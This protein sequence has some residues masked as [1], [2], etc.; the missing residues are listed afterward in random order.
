VTP[1]S[2][3]SIPITGLLTDAKLQVT[4]GYSPRFDQIS[5]LLIYVAGRTDVGRIPKQDLADAMGLSESQVKNLTSLA[6]AMDLVR[7]IVY[8]PTEMGSLLV[9]HDPF[10]DDLGTLW[11]CHYQIASQARNVIWNRMTNRILP[12]AQQPVT[13]ASVTAEF[14]DLR[15]RFS[16]RSVDKHVPKEIQ[17]FLR[18]YTD[19]R[20]RK[21]EYLGDIDGG[22]LL[23]DRPTAV[24]GLVLLALALQYR[25]R[26]R[27]GATGVEIPDLCH[28][29]NSPG[30]ILNVPELGVRQMLESLNRRGLLSIESRADL[31][32]IRFG[33]DLST[34]E[35]LSAYYE[36]R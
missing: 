28:S 26:F 25:D 9:H 2:S 34:L 14:D 4:N 15:D 8:K 24:P 16:A 17:A 20:F 33:P 23:S 31:D 19:H 18:A 30:R 1:M 36:E 29:D 7:S 10:F 27:P 21:L 12:M 11:I 5:R 35:V 6:A 3:T 22:Y 32:Q 13:A